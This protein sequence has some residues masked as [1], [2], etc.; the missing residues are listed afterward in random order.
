MSLL[1]VIL[2]MSSSAWVLMEDDCDCGPP[3]PMF[4][5]PPPPIPPDLPCD[6]DMTCP[7][8]LN[9]SGEFHHKLL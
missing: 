6:M 1:F 4:N 3:P 8:F 7:N 9:V 2:Q 5:L